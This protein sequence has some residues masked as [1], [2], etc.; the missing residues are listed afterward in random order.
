MLE[1]MEKL[2]LTE[3]MQTI[4]NNAKALYRLAGIDPSAD[5]LLQFI[6][7]APQTVAQRDSAP[8]RRSSRCWKLLFQL[9][10]KAVSKRLTKEEDTLFSDLVV[11]WMEEFV[12]LPRRARGRIL[13]LLYAMLSMEQ[14]Q[15][16]TL[17][18]V[19]SHAPEQDNA[20]GRLLNFPIQFTAPGSAVS[21]DQL[22]CETRMLLVHKLN[23]WQAGT[24]ELTDDDKLDIIRMNRIFDRHGY[25]TID[26]DFSHL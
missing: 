1:T 10:E 18:S 17:L 20:N 5:D 2:Y 24:Y 16:F 3:Q 11:Y 12:A 4:A 26:V 15:P 6:M 14:E 19:P 9:N 25:Q 23:A 8:W 22:L 13:T 7:E 21:D